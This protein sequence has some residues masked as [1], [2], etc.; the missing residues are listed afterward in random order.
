M[1]LF[2]SIIGTTAANSE[3][4]APFVLDAEQHEEFVAFEPIG[5]GG[6]GTG[7]GSGTGNG[8]GSG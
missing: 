1:G 8:D 2:D 5:G 7:T 3:T 4:P 6:G